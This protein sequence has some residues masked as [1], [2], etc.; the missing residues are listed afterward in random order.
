MTAPRTWPRGHCMHYRHADALAFRLCE[1]TRNAR[2][3]ARVWTAEGDPRRALLPLLVTSTEAEARG[4]RRTMQR[5][6]ETLEKHVKAI[7]ALLTASAATASDP[8]TTSSPIG[9]SACEEVSA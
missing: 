4:D 2:P 5:L 8:A 6:A 1:A 7:R 3:L 9:S